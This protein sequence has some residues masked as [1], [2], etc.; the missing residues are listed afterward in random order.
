MAWIALENMTFHAYHGVHPE[1][2]QTGCDFIIDIYVQANTT[3]AAKKDDVS[4][5]I[6]Y[7][8]V[9]RI[10][11]MEM[12]TQRKLIETV[13][14]KIISQMKRQFMSMEGLR[15]KIR[16]LNPPLGGRVGAS[17]IEIEEDY[18]KTCPRCNKGKFSC[19]KNEDCWCKAIKIHPATRERLESEFK[20]K[21]LCKN[22]QMH[23]AG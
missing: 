17:S 21:C 2:Q 4:K 3:E 23:F 6:N 18:I 16:K 20:K 11:E 19:F 1:E 8:L 7:E 10:C 9:Y 5:T 22:C 13:A 14:A 12:R 15:I